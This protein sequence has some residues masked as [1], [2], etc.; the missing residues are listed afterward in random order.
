MRRVARET[1]AMSI[2]V[3]LLSALASVYLIEMRSNLNEWL[4]C[5]IFGDSIVLEITSIE[6]KC[7]LSYLLLEW[8]GCRTKKSE[9][10]LRMY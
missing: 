6:K 10:F 4:V 1:S 8:V 7:I 9:R 3:L 2:R 5:A